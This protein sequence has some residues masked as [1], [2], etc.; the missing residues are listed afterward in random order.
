MIKK[1]TTNP[2]NISLFYEE[3]TGQVQKMISPDSCKEVY[4]GVLRVIARNLRKDGYCLL[5]NFGEIYLVQKK[6]Q[7]NHKHPITKQNIPLPGR[8]DVEFKPFTRIK[9]YFNT[10]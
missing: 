1:P 5:P 9:D 2:T 3:L 10:K 8:V 7:D 4:L 6:P